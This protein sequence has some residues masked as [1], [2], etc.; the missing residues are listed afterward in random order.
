MPRP[1][2]KRPI[3]V[4]VTEGKDGNG[5]PT[6][7]WNAYVPMKDAYGNPIRYANGRPKSKH[8]EKSSREECEDAVR[9]FEDEQAEAIA[10]RTAG[11]APVVK[12][13]KRLHEWIRYWVY[14]IKFPRVSHNMFKDYRDTAEK[15]IIPNIDDCD[16]PDLESSAIDLMLKRIRRSDPRS[17]DKPNRAYRH[18]RMCL[19]SAVARAKETGLFWNPAMAVDAPEHESPEVTPFTVEEAKLVMTSARRRRNAAR[20]TVGSA[21]GLRPGEALALLDDDFWIID[22][23]SKAVVGRDQ[24]DTVD[25]DKVVGLLRVKENLYRR[26]WQHGC[27]DP[28]NCPGAKHKRPCSGKGQAHL[29]YHRNGCPDRGPY[30]KPG[31]TEHARMCPDRHGGIGPDGQPLPGGRLR[32]APKSKAGKRTIVLFREMT[33][34]LIAHLKAKDKERESAGELWVETGALFATAEGR[35]ILEHD[36]WE[37]AKAIL[38]EAGLP[39]ARPYDSRHTAATLLLLKGVQKRLV[40]DALGWSSEAMLKRYQHI[41]EEMRS[42]VADAI[43]GLLYDSATDL[44]TDPPPDNVVELDSVR[45]KAA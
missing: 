13:P 6:G 11:V 45:K 36:D 38:T 40:M 24:W 41:L 10:R 4:P 28:A 44:A 27:E 31:C 15:L 29:R 8:I 33:A 43:G 39:D 17:T 35:V 1:R 5:N 23:E 37:E 16:L 14:E 26:A 25:L 12:K 32:K 3:S 34:E 18:L 2:K 19:G 9:A 21:L 20:W 7:R 42:E 30:C 22:R